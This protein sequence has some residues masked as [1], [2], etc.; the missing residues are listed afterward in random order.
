MNREAEARVPDTEGDLKQVMVKMGSG[1][2]LWEL[3]IYELA[4]VI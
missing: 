2:T 4:F 1:V 3:V